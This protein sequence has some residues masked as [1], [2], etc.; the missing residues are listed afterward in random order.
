MRAPYC[1]FGNIVA[2]AY[3]P[4]LAKDSES[5]GPDGL[6]E[7]RQIGTCKRHKVYECYW[8]HF[9]AEIHLSE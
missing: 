5:E 9:A 3:T 4:L 8:A 1:G 2:G 6:H 7:F